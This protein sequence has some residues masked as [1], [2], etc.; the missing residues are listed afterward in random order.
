[1]DKVVRIFKL[2]LILKCQKIYDFLKDA[3]IILNIILIFTSSLIVPLVKNPP[4]IQET[5]V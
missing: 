2:S 5:P 1:M 4:P 3:F